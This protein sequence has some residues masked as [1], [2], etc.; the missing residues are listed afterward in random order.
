MLQLA[1]MVPATSST[2]QPTGMVVQ[3]THQTILLLASVEPTTL[4]TTQETRV[5]VVQFLHGAMLYLASVE[6]ATSPTTQQQL[7][8]V[9]ST[10]RMLNIASVEPCSTFLNNYAVRGGAIFAEYN[11]T[12]AFSGTIHFTNNR[13]KMSG[14]STSGGGV[15]MEL[16]AFS[17]S[18]N[19]RVYWENNHATLGGGIYVSDASSMSH[20]TTVATCTAR[21]M[22]LSTCWAESVQ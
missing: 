5:M 3:S 20:C 7:Q 2:T 19:T 18:P 16:S 13:A 21:K 11:S 14:Y 17:F 15:Y 22:L 1:S 6:S 10:H 4:S 8:V 12:M 9:Q